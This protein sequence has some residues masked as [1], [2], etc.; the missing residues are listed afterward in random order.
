MS[1]GIL[2]GVNIPEKT[3]YKNIVIEKTTGSH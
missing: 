1:D 3:K 2:I